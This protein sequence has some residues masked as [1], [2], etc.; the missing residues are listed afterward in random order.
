MT[1]VKIKIEVD[2][3]LFEKFREFETRYGF[4]P[5]S[6]AALIQNDIELPLE[7]VFQQLIKGR[8]LIKDKQENMTIEFNTLMEQLSDHLTELNPHLNI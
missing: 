3:E 8:K 2:V 6:F 7:E 5:C 4:S 1:D